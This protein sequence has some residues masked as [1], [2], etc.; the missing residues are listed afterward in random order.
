[1]TKEAF[2]AEMAKF[3]RRCAGCH[4][5]LVHGISANDL[6]RRLRDIAGTDDA[7]IKEAA[8]WLELWRSTGRDTVHLRVGE[9]DF[10][11]CSDKR[12]TSASRPYASCEAS[13]LKK[14]VCQG[15]GEVSDRKFCLCT[16][17][18]EAL[19]NAKT[20]QARRGEGRKPVRILFDRIGFHAPDEFDASIHT[21]MIKLL[22][23]LGVEERD[24][25]VLTELDVDLRNL[26]TNSNDY[27]EHERWK[28]APVLML[29]LEELTAICR[30]AVYLR[31]AR[32]REYNEALSRGH[33]ILGRLARGETGFEA[34]EQETRRARRS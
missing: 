11:L 17:C 14:H 33:S 29:N 24:R 2:N 32:D 25:S 26:T 5:E 12:Y 1:M 10:F 3:Q 21:S 8:H 31:D 30:F 7:L 23:G 28:S 9:K 20:E 15:C 16:R 19:A 34:F 6:W 4:G 27:Y 18:R 22:R 13:F